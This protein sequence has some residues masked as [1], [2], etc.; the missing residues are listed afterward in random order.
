M[1]F[2]KNPKNTSTSR[3]FKPIIHSSASL[4]FVLFIVITGFNMKTDKQADKSGNTSSREICESANFEAPLPKTTLEIR[5]TRS[6][7]ILS[8]WIAEKFDLDKKKL[9][10]MLNNE[11]QLKEYGFNKENVMAMFIPGTYHFYEGADEETIFNLMFLKYKE[12]WTPERLAKAE[13]IGLTPAEVIT[14]ASIVE[15]ETQRDKEKSMIAGVYLNRLNENIKLQADPTVLF[16][17]NNYRIK[18]LRRRHL[19]VESK[20]NTYLNHGLPPGP[21]CL[22]SVSSIDAVLDAEE[23]D[24]LFFC[25]QS[26]FSGYHH[27]SETYREHLQYARQ[28]RRALRSAGIG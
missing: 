16:A 7:T 26:N 10:A 20:Y 18:R 8:R 21:I 28:Y 15:D 14:L 3:Y 12:F 22:P 9:L 5:K 4:L 1:F 19:K 17:L 11:Q 2:C 24:Y 13:E 23:H 27:F 25:A 6:K